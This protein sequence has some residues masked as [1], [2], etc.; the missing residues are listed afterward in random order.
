MSTGRPRPRP[1]PP[2]TC[3]RAARTYLC[4]N[5]HADRSL[6]QGSVACTSPGTWRRRWQGLA[7]AATAETRA[8]RTSS[9][10]VQGFGRL[11][12]RCSGPVDASRQRRPIWIGTAAQ[13]LLAGHVSFFAKGTWWSAAGAAALCHA[14]HGP[15]PHDVRARR[16]EDWFRGFQGR[17]VF[18]C[19]KYK[20]G[21]SGDSDECVVRN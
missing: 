10:C 17:F 2:P 14:R 12:S 11:L 8:T 21:G 1:R 20:S 15:R 16:S 18:R 9:N 3:L 13:I 7:G 6:L 5:Y 4:G 19:C